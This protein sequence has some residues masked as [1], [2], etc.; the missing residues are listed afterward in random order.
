VVFRSV[1]EPKILRLKRRE[2]LFR[3]SLRN[4]RLFSIAPRSPKVVEIWCKNQ[5]NLNVTA[6]FLKR[7]TVAKRENSATNLYSVT[8]KA[9]TD[10]SRRSHPKG[11]KKATLSFAHNLL[12]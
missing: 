5:E 11:K 9:V 10:V 2:S 12:W 4:G 8:C 3:N 1:A 6:V 7:S